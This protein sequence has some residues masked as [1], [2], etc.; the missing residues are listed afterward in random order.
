MP[1]GLARIVWRCLEKSPALRFQTAADLAF[2]L[3]SLSNDSASAV[4]GV[5]AAPRRLWSAWVARGATLVTGLLT[6]AAAVWMIL[7]ARQPASAAPLRFTLSVADG[8]RIDDLTRAVPSPDG[9]QVALT[10]PGAGDRQLTVLT[11]SDG[12]R[13][14]L[15]TAGAA[16]FGWSPDGRWL[17]Y[18]G[19]DRA[20]Y[21]VSIESE[22]RQRLAPLEWAPISVSWSRGGD[23]FLA[24]TVAGAVS[25]VPST[26]GAARQILNV[27]PGKAPWVSVQALPDGRRLLLSRTNGETGEILLASADGSGTP[28]VIASGSWAEFVQPDLL[29]A[30]RANQIVAWRTRLDE[31]TM[32]AQPTV[33]ADGVQLRAF[34]FAASNGGTLLY[35]SQQ[36]DLRTRIAWFD[37]T[38]RESAALALEGHCRNPELSPAF[39]RVAVE[40]YQAS[41]MRDVW[42]YDLTRDSATRLTTDPSDDADPVWTHDGR[43]IIFASSRQGTVDIFKIAAGGGQPEELVVDT[44]GSTPVMD[45][46]PD[47]SQVVVLA[48]SLEPA[49]GLDLAAYSLGTPGDRR[50]ILKSPAAEI[51]GQFAASG[52]FFS[53]G[54][55]QSGRFE[56]YVEPWP[57]TGERWPISTSGGSD[58]R[59][60][61][62]GEEIFYLTPDRRLMA[63]PVRVS[64]SFV[65]GRPVELF[66]T[67]V[68]GPIG[69]GHRFP[70][71]VDRD[72]K[73]FLMY[74]SDPDGP[75]PA[76]TVLSNWRALL[77]R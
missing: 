30:Y 33:I 3:Q 58:A 73:R 17:A 47:G 40:C 41:S 50:T 24:A 63:V 37:R 65:A 60:S 46:A 32:S 75:P 72:G 43:T 38:G 36:N 77:D 31:E 15:G 34:P 70:F 57:Q 71:A 2:A 45:L 18:F 6:G 56:V 26:G 8:L 27:E 49:S 42:V 55:N 68:A 5:P 22:Q 74:V 67:R 11:L 29:I 62:T 19:S 23:I 54:S 13:R 39:D 9:L 61:P 1:P 25:V 52:K 4:A 66:Q 64:P 48:T 28:R 44:A 51:E 21:K 10:E 7:P 16:A 53:Y 69:L 59:W 20:L 76:L 14:T 35:R 12:S